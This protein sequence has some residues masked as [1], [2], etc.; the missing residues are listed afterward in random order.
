MNI[1]EEY[2]RRWTLFDVGE[3]ET[4]SEWIRSI[5]IIKNQYSPFVG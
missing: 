3:L 2:A 1:A 5:K 4:L